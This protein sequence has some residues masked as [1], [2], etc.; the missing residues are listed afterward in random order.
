M[1]FQ[2]FSP[3]GVSILI[4]IVTDPTEANRR[5]VKN[6]CLTQQILLRR[7]AGDSLM[8]G[9]TLNS[10]PRHPSLRIRLLG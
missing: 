1:L 10:V 9:I 7:S 3:Q 2:Q 4:I 8:E 6:D 5:I